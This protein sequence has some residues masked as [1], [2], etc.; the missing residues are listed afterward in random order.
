MV[1]L[2]RACLAST[3]MAVVCTV[4]RAESV[5]YENEIKPLV[6]KYC[7]GCHNDQKAKGK[8]NIARFDTTAAVVDALGSWE[9]VAKRVKSHEMPPVGSEKPT[10]EERAKFV[11]WV[12][13]LE[14]NNGDC[15]QIAS[16]ESTSWY[17]GVV[18]S[19]RLSR[20]EYEN[21]VRDL[22]GMAFPIAGLFP[23]D[24]A[25][26]EGFDNTGNALY[27]S[28]IQAE[29][30][31]KAAD[32]VVETALPEKDGNAEVR[33]RLIP[34]SPGRGAKE[35]AAARQAITSFLE[36]AWRRPVT[37][38]E[39]DRLYKLYEQDRKGRDGFAAGLK[40]AYKAALVSSNFLFLAEPQPEQPGVYLLGGYPLASRLSYFLWSSMPDEE[41]FA[42]AKAD[43]LREPDQLRAQV[44][45]MLLDP[46]AKALGQVFGEQWLGIT[47]IGQ[48]IKPDPNKFAEFDDSLA[49]A[50]QDEA[51]SFFHRIVSEDR[52]L[53]ELINSDYTY[54]NAKLATVYGITGVSGDTMQLVSLQDPNRGGVLGMPAVLTATSHALRT[55]PVLRGKWVLEQLLGDEV[56][57]PPPNVPKLPDDDKPVDGLTLRQQLEVHRRNPD[58]AGCHA[59]MDPI[60]FG[61]ENFDPI[62]RWRTDLAGQAIDSQ[63]TLPSGQAF[64][65]PKE[66]KAILLERKVDFTRNLSRKMLGYAL[67]RNVA[68]MDKCVVDACLKNL[69]QADYRASALFDTI[70]LSHPFRHR[71][72]GGAV[73]PPEVKPSEPAKK[74]KLTKKPGA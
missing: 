28:A 14:A 8:F 38:E 54:V 55:S 41:L 7:V 45:R 27:I 48:T 6:A 61:L 70:V 40:L 71:Y 9:R 52:S 63:G 64:S 20:A 69:E 26:G 47:Q 18:M 67:G 73:A 12:E 17:P 50:M 33:A 53:L 37:E 72:S 58:C 16:E 25:G 51:A 30:Y 24:G 49:A 13:A 23:A 44:R 57:P 65:G 2:L 56:P 46:K 59:R 66:L 34:A 22:F 74:V 11:A 4:S 19:R 43:A 29:K 5:P 36:R 31:L 3:A 21:S 35:H 10:D 62:G 68:K 1:G 42:A 32:V 15:N 39:V 60:G